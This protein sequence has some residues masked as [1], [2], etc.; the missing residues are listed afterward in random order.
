VR[1]VGDHQVDET[2][3]VVCGDQLKAEEPIAIWGNAIY[4]DGDLHGVYGHLHLERDADFVE[5]KR[6]FEALGGGLERIEA[7]LDGLSPN[8]DTPNGSHPLTG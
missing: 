2:L 8:N 7:A 1:L 4:H 5:L 3:C 6:K